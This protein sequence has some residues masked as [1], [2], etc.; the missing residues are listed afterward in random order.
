M[1]SWE[2]L[3]AFAVIFAAF[4]AAPGPAVAAVLAR[5]MAQGSTGMV[6][7]VG[8]LMLGD[9]VWFMIA[10]FGLAALA[11]L[12]QPVFF[13]LKYLGAAYLLYLAWKLW[14]A[15]V[16]AA[17]AEP[18]RGQGL[19]L[20]GGGLLLTMSNPKTMLFYL[21]VLP[22]LIDLPSL[23]AMGIVEITGAIVV[24]FGA[25]FTAIVVLAAQV[26]RLFTSP[27]AVRIVNRTSGVAMAG[28]AAAIA[29]RD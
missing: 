4:C 3:I 28:A 14:N 21:A 19:K 5:V 7:F 29:L 1:V 20:F 8:G 25:V 23:T 26:R 17:T 22:A 15:P 18:V 13:V 6:W 2:A 16:T 24:V 11:T 12:V 9:V 10:A 27:R